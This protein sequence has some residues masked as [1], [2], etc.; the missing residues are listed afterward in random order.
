MNRWE[1][2]L[3]SVRDHAKINGQVY[4]I[5]GK[6]Y[7]KQKRAIIALAVIFIAVIAVLVIA[8]LVTDFEAGVFCILAFCVYSFSDYLLNVLLIPKKIEDYVTLQEG[9]ESVSI[10]SLEG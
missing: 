9:N 2:A 4:K 5:D 10:D 6:I 3:L 7:E 1:F 8:Q